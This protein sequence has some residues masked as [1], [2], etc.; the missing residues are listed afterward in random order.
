[1]GQYSVV[2]KK[3]RR[4][5]LVAL[6]QIFQRLGSS[7]KEKVF[8][9]ADRAELAFASPMNHTKSRVRK[10]VLLGSSRMTCR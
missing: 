5:S 9:L 4:V 8:V 3:R 10:V 7:R 6:A 1:M 2:A